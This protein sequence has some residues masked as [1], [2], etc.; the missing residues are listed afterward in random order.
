MRE[1]A[2]IGPTAASA[3]PSSERVVWVVDQF[4]E[5]FT[6]CHDDAEREAFVATLL[7]AAVRLIF[8]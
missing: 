6:L 5:I 1:G 4:E 7:T 3:R 8:G 2:M